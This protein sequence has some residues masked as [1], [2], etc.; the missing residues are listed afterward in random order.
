[1]NID[2]SHMAKRATEPGARST[3]GTAMQT[4]A[5]SDSAHEDGS[6]SGFQSLADRVEIEALR[7]EF[8]D[9]V[10]MR[11]YDR[12]AS[13]FTADGAWRIPDIPVDLVG[14]KAVS[15][16]G[17][18]VPDVVQYLVQN[19]APRHDPARRQHRVRP[20]VHP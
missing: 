2:T 13:L 9:A 12:V 7:A 11:D 15:A 14:Q 5:R 1:M 6:S 16:W 17:A 20:C 19:G 10:M 4:Y 3:A 18:H 8:T